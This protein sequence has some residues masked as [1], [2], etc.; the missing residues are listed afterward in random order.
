MSPIDLLVE[1]TVKSSLVV[2]AALVAVARLRRRSAALRHWMLSAGITAALASPLLGLVVPSWHLPLDR[3]SRPRIID[4]VA[5]ARG[6]RLPATA[7]AEASA[8]TAAAGVALPGANAIVSTAWI[9]GA[10]VSILILL[11]GLGRLVWI[12]SRAR[13]VVD[14][15]WAAAAGD[16]AREYGL[17]RPIV[18]LQSDHPALLVTWGFVEPKVILPRSAED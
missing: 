11:A 8:S 12:A 15:R 4:V 5:P 16:I 17:R 13:R 7:T 10:A 9:G 3:L 14:G 2:V 6:L 1:T 18:I